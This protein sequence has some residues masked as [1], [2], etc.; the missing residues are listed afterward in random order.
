MTL[1]LTQGASRILGFPRFSKY[2]I[3]AP[4]PFGIAWAP[5][6]TRA[7]PNSPSELIALSQVSNWLIQAMSY[8][9]SED[10]QRA[11]KL[12][13]LRSIAEQIMSHARALFI[14]YNVSCC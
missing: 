4:R 12:Q 5:A 13:R 11:L 6:T 7:L 3:I 10:F 2:G 14:H 8:G 9:L 1:Y